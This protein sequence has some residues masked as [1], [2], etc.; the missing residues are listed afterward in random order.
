MT[1]VCRQ[2]NN[3]YTIHKSLDLVEMMNQDLRVVK[4]KYMQYSTVENGSDE[5]IV[6]DFIYT[7]CNS[8]KKSRTPC[9]VFLNA[10]NEWSCEFWNLD[11]FRHAMVSGGVLTRSYYVLG[12][13][14]DCYVDIEFI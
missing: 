7:C 4:D 6:R 1:Q 13:R 2:F 11:R 3:L 10:F 14:M 5:K 12:I 8:K 9:I